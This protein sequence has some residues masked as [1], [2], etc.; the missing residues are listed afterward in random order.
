MLNLTLCF[1]VN[2]SERIRDMRISELISQEYKCAISGLPLSPDNSA[3]DHSHID[4]CCGENSDG[5]VRGVILPQ[6]NLLEGKFL[7]QFKKFKLKEKYGLDFPTFLVN[8][9]EYLKEDNSENLLHYGFYDR[10]QRPY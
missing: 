8:M 1:G 9:G 7:K 10:L 6:I 5:R 3:L 4:S 2:N